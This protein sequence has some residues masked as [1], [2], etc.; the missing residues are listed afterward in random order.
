MAAHPVAAYKIVK[1]V[2]NGVT[3]NVLLQDCLPVTQPNETD[4]DC[5]ITAFEPAG[6]NAASSETLQTESQRSDRNLVDRGTQPEHRASLLHVSEPANDDTVDDDS[7]PVHTLSHGSELA[8]DT[9]DH[10]SEPVRT[11]S[12][13]S[14]PANVDTV[15]DDSEPVHTLSHGSELANDTVYHDSEPVHTLSPVIEPAD[16]DTVDHDSEPIDTLSCG[17]ELADDDTVDDDSEP[18]RTLSHGSEPA[19]IDTVDDDSEPVHTLSHGG[20]LA[21]DTVDDDSEPVHTLSHGSESANVDTVDD[22]SE[23][24]HTLSPVSEPANVY[25]VDEDSEPVRTLSHGSEPANVDTVDHN[26]EPVHTL[27]SEPANDEAGDP[28]TSP[29]KEPV[30]SDISLALQ[31]CVTDVPS[32]CAAVPCSSNPHG[33]IVIPASSS[34]VAP[35][36]STFGINQAAALWQQM[37]QMCDN[38]VAR[39]TAVGIAECFLR[40]QLFQSQPSATLA[41]PVVMAP[42]LG[43]AELPALSGISSPRTMTRQEAMAAGW[44]A[45]ND[46]PETSTLPGCS[47]DN[48]F[49]SSVELVSQ[50]DNNGGCGGRNEMFRSSAE[51]ML[52]PDSHA[53]NSMGASQ[54]HL[55][56]NGIKPCLKSEKR[57]DADENGYNRGFMTAVVEGMMDTGNA[58]LDASVPDVK[59]VM[60]K[61][62][63][64]LG[65]TKLRVPGGSR[66]VPAGGMDAVHGAETVRQ[67]PGRLPKKK[68]NGTVGCPTAEQHRLKDCGV[69]LQQLQLSSSTVN[70]G[71]VGQH[72]CCRELAPRVSGSCRLCRGRP[73]ISVELAVAKKFRAGSRK[74]ARAAKTSREFSADAELL[75]QSAIRQR[76]KTP[77]KM[78]QMSNSGPPNPPSQESK[79]YLMIKTETGGTFVV[80][81]ESA[82]GCIISEQEIAQI[83][84]SWS[85][86]PSTLYPREFSNETLLAAC[87]GMEQRNSDEA[88]S[89]TNSR[90]ESAEAQNMSVST[91]VRGRPRRRGPRQRSRHLRY[92]RSVRST[93]VAAASRIAKSTSRRLS[94]D[95]VLKARRC[96]RGRSC[97]QRELRALGVDGAKPS[98]T[99][100]RHSG[101]KRGRGR[102]KKKPAVC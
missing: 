73:S 11:L 57:F 15:D 66:A 25:T 81:V 91:A 51:E 9:V 26:S 24:V 5:V 8:S 46:G 28:T 61:K 74:C 83:L 13:G 67:H 40:S 38:I 62:I 92:L 22:D 12:H 42:A 18:V 36:P 79:K 23:P 88:A 14:E 35:P 97:L 53:T 29:V 77:S 89:S 94:A 2:S 71:V 63:E 90:P 76:K 75:Q 82:K 30:S 101:A 72:L 85:S 37:R 31:S 52:V 96:V 50:N 4:D 10:N 86:S 49:V 48:S 56:A 58:V 55:F 33:G 102:P 45:A 98:E 21:N 43:T 60:S 100:P 87:S 59:P 47:R 80:P 41:N 19:D 6:T 93:A 39:S 20:E 27:S 1:V 84:S 7:E 70:V 69:W 44:F 3:K 54:P 32:T 34:T 78:P 95:L 65:T 99:V 16:D 64:C 17:S 68:A